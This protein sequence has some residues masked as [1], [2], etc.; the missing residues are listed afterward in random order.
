[1]KHGSNPS[2]AVVAGILIAGSL[3]LQFFIL[4]AGR[5][6]LDIRD[7]PTRFTTTFYGEQALAFLHGGLAL[8]RI[9]P[10]ALLALSDPYDPIARRGIDALHDAS[11]YKGKY[12]LYFGPG[13]ALALLPFQLFAPEI[14]IPDSALV[15]GLSTLL[16][17]ATGGLLRAVRSRLFPSLPIWIA[18]PL[19]LAILVG[20]PV[21]FVLARPA[22]YEAAILGG[23]LGLICGLFFA[24]LARFRRRQWVFATFAGLSFGIAI[25]SRFTLLPAVTLCCLTFAVFLWRQPGN[26]RRRWTVFGLFVPVVIALLLLGWFNF[27]RFGSPF[28][29]GHRF[30]LTLF[31]LF[32]EYSRFFSFD[33]LAANCYALLL[34]PPD[35]GATFPFLTAPGTKV[36]DLPAWTGRN[37]LLIL[38][39]AVG[40][41]VSN[42][43]LL[44][45]LAAAAIGSAGIWKSL[46]GAEGHSTIKAPADLPARR[47][48]VFLAGTV[49]L[50]ALPD[51]LQ[52]YATMRY[53]LDFSPLLGLLSFAGAGL[54]FQSK[55][56]TQGPRRAV[57]SGVL[58][59]L[60]FSSVGFGVLLGVQGYYRHFQ[61]HN[62]ALFAS[63]AIPTIPADGSADSG[64]DANDEGVQIRRLDASFQGVGTLKSVE[65][66]NRIWNASDE[67]P[68]TLRWNRTAPDAAGSTG[69]LRLLQSGYRPLLEWTVPLGIDPRQGDGSSTAITAK[70]PSK[71]EGPDFLYLE[72]RVSSSAGEAIGIRDAE[73]RP[74][75]DSILAGP[76]HLGDQGPW[77]PSGARKINVWYG[78]DL[79]LVGVSIDSIQAGSEGPSILPIALYWSAPLYPDRLNE[80]WNVRIAVVDQSGQEIGTAG[81]EPGE[82]W[83]PTTAWAPGDKIVDEWDIPIT[84]PPTGPGYRLWI[85]VEGPNGEIEPLGNA[86]VE[87]PTG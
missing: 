65:F 26:K 79:H 6:T 39:P 63:L 20:N 45:A 37:P 13:P 2:E 78:V 75:G 18:G 69:K 1:M 35:V 32:A 81:G 61:T 85:H 84:Q 59:V 9:P 82:G 56:L 50:A 4:T 83:Y 51:L 19:A 38:E 30:Q 47:L 10:Q 49:T 22:V 72:L 44:L 76:I 36:S 25:A 12:F 73:G 7:Q 58:L 70:L 48:A 42:P 24:W 52:R 21:L 54:L 55:S 71:V 77:P 41:L 80:P 3:L 34:Q 87:I 17:V 53:A 64:A 74:A 68:I 27:A 15:A 16:T 60:A 46:P 31:P 23:Q 33:Y 40:I 62:P 11:L 8:E 67:I 57:L 86:T 5:W 14:P 28:E 66:P 29:T 43:V